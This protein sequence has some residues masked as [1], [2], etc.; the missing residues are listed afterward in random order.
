MG[1]WFESSFSMLQGAHA[2]LKHL[3]KGTDASKGKGDLVDRPI[4]K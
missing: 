4:E 2:C 1:S 3:E